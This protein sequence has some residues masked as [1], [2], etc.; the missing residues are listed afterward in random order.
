MIYT[1]KHWQ[2][3]FAALGTPEVF[4]AD[5][6]FASMTTRTENIDAIYSELA[7]LLLTRTTDEWMELFDKADIPAMP[8]AS[9][10]IATIKPRV[11]F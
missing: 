11:L 8:L 7:D 1:D 9:P 4:E 5:S 2:S 3:W 6:R 10:D